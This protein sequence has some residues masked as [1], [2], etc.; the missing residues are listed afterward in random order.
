M[1]VLACKQLE[2]FTYVK[3]LQVGQK[4]FTVTFYFYHFICNFWTLCP[5]FKAVFF[6]YSTLLTLKKHHSAP[7]M[8]HLFNYHLLVHIQACEG[9][10]TELNTCQ[11]SKRRTRFD[12]FAGEVLTL[13]WGHK[14]NLQS[15]RDKAGPAQIRFYYKKANSC[16]S[17]SWRK[18]SWNCFVFLKCFNV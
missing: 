1:L 6:S 2:R 13:T 14:K 3:W 10:Q 7:P 11:L 17:E 16:V 18:I 9:E 12:W 4:H 5:V 8:L 15:E